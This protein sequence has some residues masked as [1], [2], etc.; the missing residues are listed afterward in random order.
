M[1][2]KRRKSNRRASSKAGSMDVRQR[3]DD[4]DET[5]NAFIRN[6]SHEIR[7]P[8]N[9]IMGFA[10]MLKQSGLSSQQTDYVDVILDSGNKLLSI[11]E[12]LLDL[13]N[14]QLGKVHLNTTQCPLEAVFRRVWQSHEPMII[15]KNLE[16]KLLL[17]PDLPI[18]MVD[19]DK[20]QRVLGFVLSN[21][22]KFTDQGFV[23]LKVEHSRRDD[24]GFWVDIYVED[25]GCGIEEERIQQIFGAFE[26][27]D[28]SLTRSYAGLG[29]G[30][31]LSSRLVELLGG[32]ISAS[33]MPG[34]G[35]MF[36]VRIPVEKA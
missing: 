33:S 23:S 32:E 9:A 12:N 20:L 10:Q 14:L 29:L 6:I 4:C 26:Q 24:E 18:V 8:M 28:N 7:T 17:D 25:S 1:K 35:S 30:L 13:S 21:A 19:C 22:V 11:L 15:A 36:H 27:A 2:K 16:A 3:P 5:K 34:K 31:G